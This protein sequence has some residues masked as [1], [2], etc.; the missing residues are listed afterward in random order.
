MKSIM[1]EDFGWF[2][3]HGCTT[4]KK[5][6]DSSSLARKRAKS[7]WVALQSDDS[8][9]LMPGFQWFPMGKLVRAKLQDGTSFRGQRWSKPLA[10]LVM[11]CFWSFRAFWSKS[12]RG[13]T[14]KKI[15]DPR[16]MRIIKVKVSWRLS[17][18]MRMHIKNRQSIRS[19]VGNQSKGSS[20]R[21]CALRSAGENVKTRK[22]PIVLR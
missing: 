1:L 13:S 7:G 18:R 3:L 4:L 5:S 14:T 21:F 16:R 8:S 15:A 17:W 20:R 19:A 12:F 10:R 9:I 2:W 11:I 22:L 6:L